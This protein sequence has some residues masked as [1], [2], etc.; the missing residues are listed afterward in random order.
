[1]TIIQEA[2]MS[3]DQNKRWRQ[4]ILCPAPITSFSADMISE[5]GKAR[6][7]FPGDRLT[8]MALVE[9]VGELAKAMLDEPAQRVY[10]E[11][12]QVAAM[13]ARLAIEGDSSVSEVR[14]ERGLNL[15]GLALCPELPAAPK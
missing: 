13:A 5:I 4:A 7:K 9:E 6:A 1:M 14:I 2:Y 3:E 8:M 11:A 10:R 12:V 15:W